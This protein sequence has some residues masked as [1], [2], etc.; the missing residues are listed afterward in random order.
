MSIKNPEPGES[1]TFFGITHHG[2][3]TSHKFTWGYPVPGEAPRWV[4]RSW[5]K[6]KWQRSVYTHKPPET[7]YRWL[8]E[9]ANRFQR[10]LVGAKRKAKA[11]IARRKRDAERILH[12]VKQAMRALE[13][14]GE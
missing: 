3:I 4:C 6:N 12:E 7:L 13:V 2:L 10:T 11:R 5:V 8:T 14:P 9:D 1:F